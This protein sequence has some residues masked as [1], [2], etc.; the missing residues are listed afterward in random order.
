MTMN[1]MVGGNECQSRITYLWLHV[2]YL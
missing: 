1:V 2:S